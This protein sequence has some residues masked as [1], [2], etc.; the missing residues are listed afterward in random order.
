MSPTNEQIKALAE[1]WSNHLGMQVIAATALFARNPGSALTARRRC[2]NIMK[3][4]IA[5]GA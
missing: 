5:E 2:A 4:E 1:R 3:A